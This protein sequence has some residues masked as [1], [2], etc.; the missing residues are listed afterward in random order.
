MSQIEEFFAFLKTA[1]VTKFSIEFGQP[2]QSI[3]TGI[4]QGK[5]GE[6]KT[7]VQVVDILPVPP[8]PKQEAASVLQEERKIPEPNDF[9]KTFQEVR[10]IMPEPEPVKVD[11]PLE[12]KKADIEDKKPD[13]DLVEE[14]QN[15]P[16][17]ADLTKPAEPAKT[18]KSGEA[19][20]FI[21]ESL[22]DRVSYDLFNEICEKD[23]GSEK[24]KELK[25]AALLRMSVDGLQQVNLDFQLG[26]NTDVPDKDLPALIAS[27]F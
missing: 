26:F 25:Q 4:D 6:D 11:K 20:E 14:K 8:K 16:W 23:N 5:P 22:P 10:D 13:A 2:Q 27:A 24:I 21:V 3:W 9:A 1:G 19:F 12:I 17:P 7:A 18:E 15:K